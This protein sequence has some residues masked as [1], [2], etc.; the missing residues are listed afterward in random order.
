MTAPEPAPSCSRGPEPRRGHRNVPWPHRRAL[1]PAELRGHQRRSRSSRRGSR[2]SS[3]MVRCWWLAGLLVGRWHLSE[4]RGVGEGGGELL[5]ASIPTGGREPARKPRGGTGCSTG[6]PAAQ[7]EGAWRCPVAR[8]AAARG[9]FRAGGFSDLRHL[10][11]KG[12]LQK[13]SPPGTRLW[14][15]PGGTGCVF[16]AA[17][18]KGLRLTTPQFLELFQK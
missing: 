2:A 3:T 18:Q 13:P 11:G 9:W 10:P 5:A 1:R 17:F 7:H 8:S 14:D 12:A 6:C 15:P 4:R 16:A